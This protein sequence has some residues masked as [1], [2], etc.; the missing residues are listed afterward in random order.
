MHCYTYT[1]DLNVAKH[2]PKRVKRYEILQMII[3][4]LPT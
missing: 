4:Q 2:L 3:F 1:I